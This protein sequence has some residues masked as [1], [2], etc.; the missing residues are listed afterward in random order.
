MSDLEKKKT[1][2][3]DEET[4]NTLRTASHSEQTET[5]DNEIDDFTQRLLDRQTELLLFPEE[6][7]EV[8]TSILENTMSEEQRRNAE[9]T[10]LNALDAMRKERGQQTI[11]EEEKQFRKANP[12]RTGYGKKH[13][14]KIHHSS[15]PSENSKAG[16]GQSG[17]RYEMS[18]SGKL[19]TAKDQPLVPEKKK[20]WQRRSVQ[21]AAIVIAMLGVL[22]G[23]YVWKVMV[24]NPQHVSSASQTAAYDRLVSYAD[25]YLMMSDAQ[26][27]NLV[28]LENDYNILPQAKKK[29]IDVYFENP[30]H[31]GST[32]PAL[33]EQMKNKR[34]E[35]QN[36]T[37]NDLLSY[38]QSYNPADEAIASQILT[39]I[40]AFN[41]L[42]EE[43]RAKVD[44][45]M[46]QTSGKTFTETYNDYVASRSQSTDSE[47]SEAT[48]G[49]D[50][51][52]I[53][54]QIDSLMADR[55][56]YA[57][58]LVSEGLPEDDILAQYDSQIAALQ[59]E[60]G[61]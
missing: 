58:F 4:D 45:A 57:E 6:D 44:D 43:S 7:E 9:Q 14:P 36:S 61:Y 1:A 59:A 2:R 53:Q 34:Q 52:V 42:D 39:R 31:T 20:F 26:K 38:A 5:G 23:A 12:S 8:T 15:K 28:N 55:E 3:S 49:N 40:D 56:A 24:Y 46:R 54:A 32:F 29:E 19:T 17:G 30:K 11:E 48:V 13:S 10:M 35:N 18:G 51:A 47:T 21:A 37:F 41:A 16:A 60:L 27:L 33:L 25:Q 50:T 22:F